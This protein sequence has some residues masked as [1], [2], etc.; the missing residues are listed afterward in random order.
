MMEGQANA[1]TTALS[2]MA[3]PDPTRRR[4]GA[5]YVPRSQPPRPWFAVLLLIP[6]VA[7]GWSLAWN[8]F[9]VGQVVGLMVMCLVPGLLFLGYAIPLR[10]WTR[11]D[12]NLRGAAAMASRRP[13][14]CAV[15]CSISPPAACT[16]T[17]RKFEP[18]SKR[19]GHG[20]CSQRKPREG[21]SNA[22]AL[23]LLA[24]LRN[25]WACTCDSCDWRLRPAVRG[26]W[27][28]CNGTCMS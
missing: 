26:R 20:R 18:P 19:R 13:P 5:L 10:F 24:G 28:V 17:Q 6:P 9:K 25:V 14:A 23:L 12:S 15:N 27:L 11:L 2:L 7:V 22:Q 21:H 3:L 1:P 8:G 16:D 4:G